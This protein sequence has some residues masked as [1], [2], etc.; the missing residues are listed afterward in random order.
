LNRRKRPDNQ[1]V[2]PATERREPPACRRI[3]GAERI[4]EAVLVDQSTIS[5]TPRSNPVTYT[6]AFDIICDLFASTPEADRRGWPCAVRQ[7]WRTLVDGLL[8]RS[9]AA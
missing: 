1:A 9:A 2:W 7:R 4:K 6:K 3:E 8:A 5:R